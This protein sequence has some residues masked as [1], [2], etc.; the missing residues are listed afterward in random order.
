MSRRRTTT[1]TSAP[2][3]V[4]TA[5]V[6]EEQIISTLVIEEPE[7]V[8]PEPV[9]T[10]SGELENRLAELEAKY[11]KLVGALRMNGQVSAALNKFY[12]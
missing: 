11:E 4:T 10:E 6:E 3:D 8:A 5:S 1:T 2:V 12:D 7:T 9:A